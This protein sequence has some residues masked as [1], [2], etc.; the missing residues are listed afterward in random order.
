MGQRSYTAT[1]C[2]RVTIADD[3][4]RYLEGDEERRQCVIV[5]FLAWT[6]AER[7]LPVR[8]T[9]GGSAWFH[10][11]DYDIADAARILAWLDKQGFE[12]PAPAPTGKGE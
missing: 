3:D 4:A 10:Y 7:I 9:S 8:G 12:H 6:L 11:G 2:L 1:N 5:R